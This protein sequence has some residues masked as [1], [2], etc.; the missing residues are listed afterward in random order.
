MAH[1]DTNGNYVSADSATMSG[2]LYQE[3]I[4]EE[5]VC[6]FCIYKPKSSFNQSSTSSKFSCHF[7]LYLISPNL[8]FER[9]SLSV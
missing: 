9:N 5:K 1:K 2:D 4:P 8:E 3:Q 7:L 6:Y